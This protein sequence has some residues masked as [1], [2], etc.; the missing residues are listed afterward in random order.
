MH[1][2]TAHTMLPVA[3]DWIDIPQ[4]G[5]S[6]PS[7]IPCCLPLLQRLTAQVN[8]SCI[9]RNLWGCEVKIELG[10]KQGGSNKRRRR[11]SWKAQRR[12]L[13]DEVCCSVAE[14]A[15]G[16]TLSSRKQLWHSDKP[17]NCQHG[18]GK[19]LWSKLVLILALG[20]RKFRKKTNPLS[21]LQYN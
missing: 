5:Q 4:R 9:Q 15:L 8:K 10:G 7:I 19:L 14:S 2:I 6:L 20:G 11:K 3:C 12:H 18:W 17:N 1:F 16:G 13:K 21:E